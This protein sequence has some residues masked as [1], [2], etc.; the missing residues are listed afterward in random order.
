[1]VSAAS[2]RCNNGLIASAVVVASWLNNHH[3]LP[4]LR[5]MEG[6]R[7]RNDITCTRPSS[8]EYYISLGGATRGRGHDG[9]EMLGCSLASL[10]AAG[11]AAIPRR[12][13]S[14][15]SQMREQVYE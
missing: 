14:T 9:E 12:G 10:S 15:S 7:R 4:H 3:L 8:T 1:M 11:A 2:G 6:V 5:N 13:M